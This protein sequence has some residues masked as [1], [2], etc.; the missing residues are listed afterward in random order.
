MSR[1]ISLP[2]GSM[3]IRNATG[4]LTAT[5]TPT[6]TPTIATTPGTSVVQHG[7]TMLLSTSMQRGQYANGDWFVFNPAGG[8]GFSFVAGGSHDAVTDALGS[9]FFPTEACSFTDSTNAVTVTGHRA[10]VGQQVMFMSIVATT[11]IVTATIYF[12]RAILTSST[13]TIAATPGGAEINLV[14]NGTGTIRMYGATERRR[15]G[16]MVNPGNSA[17]AYGGTGS[18]A[19]NHRGNS[20]DQGYDQL[21]P[22]T[23]ISSSTGQG[24]NGA[25]NVAEAKTFAPGEEGSYVKAV[26]R[27]ATPDRV[28]RDALS[29]LIVVTVVNTLPPVGS[30]RPP[31]A[32]T[33][34]TPVINQ[35]QIS[36]SRFLSLSR[37]TNS[38]APANL[39]TLIG[40]TTKHW[41]CG[42]TNGLFTRA[43]TPSTNQGVIGQDYGADYAKHLSDCAAALHYDFAPAELD[44]LAMNLCVIGADIAYV[45][46][47]GAEF[48]G[49][50][51]TGGGGANQFWKMPVVLAALLA[52][53]S[54]AYAIMAE[55]CDFAQHQIFANDTQLFRVSQTEFDTPRHTGDGRTRNAYLPYMIGSPEWGSS[56]KGRVDGDGGDK[57]A[58]A[59][60]DVAYRD[61][62]ASPQTVFWCSAARATGGLALV[63][64]PRWDAYHR[65]YADWSNNLAL[66]TSSNT[67][68]FGREFLADN[69]PAYPAT[70]PVL[71]ARYA[72]ENWVY[73]EFDRPLRVNEAKPAVGDFAVTVDG[74]SATLTGTV[75]V[76][77]T[78][79]AVQLATPLTA[80][81]QAVTIGYTAGANRVR[82]LGGTEVP[83]V[84]AG[85]AT[86]QTLLPPP[87]AGTIEYV[88]GD[89]KSW[90]YAPYLATTPAEPG[91]GKLLVGVQFKLTAAPASGQSIIG[92]ISDNSAG[93]RVFNATSTAARLNHR[94]G[95]SG[96]AGT[97]RPSTILT[98]LVSGS[99]AIIWFLVDGDQVGAANNNRASI[100]G[101]A[102]PTSSST[103]AQGNTFDPFAALMTYGIS[104]LARGGTTR[105]D[106]LAEN[107]FGGGISRIFIDWGPPGDTV[108][109]SNPVGTNFG[110]SF[111]WGDYGELVTGRRPKFFF[112]INRADALAAGIVNRGTVRNWV[113]AATTRD[114]DEVTPVFVTV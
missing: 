97:N 103:D 104:P 101:V 66:S 8:A 11:G 14:T 89:G 81:T 19:T 35:S 45:A 107:A 114:A 106:N 82:T 2:M 39:T 4:L 56:V 42:F 38:A 7:V 16:A 80:S 90:L 1:R 44:Q 86:N 78:K 18:V 109:P 25:L 70:A 64:N 41:Q 60:F 59:Q 75:Q 54:P 94:Q 99:E 113:L 87:P 33:S 34:K 79:I 49:G 108:I 110:L 20:F 21:T 52:P 26:S 15:N 32:A 50:T 47:Q 76:F 112:P 29:E 98:G 83:T 88:A 71:V 77:D 31:V 91:M 61:F 58:G 92:N 24:Y 5:P 102:S 30:L 12:V 95:V 100:N 65:R 84:T 17:I 22:P 13:F 105:L 28:G 43:I 69:I 40:Y 23:G 68:T 27:S 57:Y 9:W 6:P 46:A 3:V 72:Q 96:G 48:P 73:L 62:N 74:P 53:T 10:T 63:N 37:A 51:T 85:A 67:T 93:L 111:N 36:R 55:Y